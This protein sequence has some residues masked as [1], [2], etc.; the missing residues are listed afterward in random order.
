VNQRAALDPLAGAPLPCILTVVFV[1][2]GLMAAAV[3][4]ISSVAPD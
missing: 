4:S 3:E 1:K 2:A